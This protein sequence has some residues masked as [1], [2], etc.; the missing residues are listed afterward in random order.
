LDAI[1]INFT[2]SRSARRSQGPLTLT[3]ALAT[4]CNIYFQKLGIATGIDSISEWAQRLGLGELSGIDLPGEFA[5]TRASKATKRLRN[6]Q[7]YDKT[8]FKADTAQSAIGQFDNAFT[9]VQLARYTAALATGNLVSPHVIQD[10]TAEDGTVLFT[11]STEV[12]PIGISATTLASIRTAME[13]VVSSEEG[14][15]YDYLGDFPIP[16][17]CKTGTAETGFEDS[18]NSNGLFVC[19]APANDPQIAIALVVEQGEWGSST[20]VIAKKLLLSYFE[21]SDPSLTDAEVSDPLIGDIFI[22]IAT[23]SPTP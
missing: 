17:A 4:S 7:E 13:A 20:A 19:Y 12:S 22:P 14:T 15:A 18:K 1:R 10:V 21:L 5:G 16:L 8:W 23:P 3:R 2:V 6:V 9:I 11:G